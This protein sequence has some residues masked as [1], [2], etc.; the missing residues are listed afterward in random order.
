MINENNELVITTAEGFEIIRI[1]N[2]IN[3]KNDISKAINQFAELNSKKENK[4]NELRELIINEIGYKEY[5]NLSESDKE[6]ATSKILT[7]HKEFKDEFEKSILEVNREMASLGMDL[8]YEFVIKIPEAE[9]EIYKALSKIF[10]KSLK[11]IETQELDITIE[12]I[13]QIAE[14]KTVMAFFNL[15][16]K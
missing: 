12:Q 2:K 7:D 6:E 9:K 16:T 3:M 15:A 13:K 8:V 4:L 1:L 11:E 5:E 10:N 14:S